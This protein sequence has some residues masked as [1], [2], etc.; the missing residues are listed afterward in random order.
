MPIKKISRTLLI[1]IFTLPAIHAEYIVYKKGL[2]P[3]TDIHEYSKIYNILMNYQWPMS[4]GYAN[5]MS[6][7]ERE[8]LFSS[9]PNAEWI[10]L[11][12]KIKML[13]PDYEIEFIPTLLYELFAIANKNKIP[14]LSDLETIIE[15][16]S[17][18]SIDA[19]DM[20]QL[21]SNPHASL[22]TWFDYY[23]RT[24]YLLQ[25]HLTHQASKQCFARTFETI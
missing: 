6:P 2:T 19:L 12:Y 10:F 15:N 8:I 13:S 7:K 18:Y 1:I 20:K 11:R 14:A 9:K 21:V 17:T 3:I 22:Q 23:R 5:Q 24:N 25:T 4:I 16:N